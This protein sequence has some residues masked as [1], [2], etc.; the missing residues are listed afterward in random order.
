M[1]C[2]FRLLAGL[3]LLAALPASAYAADAA[4]RWYTEKEAKKGAALYATHCAVCHGAAGEGQPGWEQRDEMGF[5]PPPPVNAD[6]HAWHHPLTDM[7]RVLDTGGGPT[8]G[9]MPSFVDVL[10]ER[11][12]RAVIAYVQSLW[13]E[14]IYRQWVEIDAGRAEPP[15]VTQHEGH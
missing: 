2:P 3:L 9:T 8:G 5:Y 6:G 11:D 15:V 14:E 12:K 1:N 13:P 7:L 4:S 10:K